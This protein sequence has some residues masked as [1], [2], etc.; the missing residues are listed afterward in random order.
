ML[1]VRGDGNSPAGELSQP[2]S[3]LQKTLFS[4]ALLSFLSF[5]LYFHLCH[6]PSLLPFYATPGFPSPLPS[7]ASA[8]SESPVFPLLCSATLGF[9]LLCF[10]QVSPPLPPPDFSAIPGFP[11]LCNPWPPSSLLTHPCFP[12][13]YHLQASFSIAAPGFLLLCYP[14]LP[15]PPLCYSVLP[16]L[17]HPQAT[18]SS[19]TLRF[20]LL[21][22]P[23][24]SLSCSNPGFP[25]L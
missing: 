14:R 12:F 25:L 16:L 20:P 5:V 9:P 6:N 17:Y 1:P 11:L 13:L 24:A 7:Q 15:P 21:C 19:T 18:L 23:K 22:Y 2:S 4:N 8:S 3:I 10:P